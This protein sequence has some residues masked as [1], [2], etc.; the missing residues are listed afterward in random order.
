MFVAVSPLM[1]SC[2]VMWALVNGRRVVVLWIYCYN[3]F[4][5]FFLLYFS[6]LVNSFYLN[7][8]SVL[9]PLL[10]TPVEGEV[11]KQLCGAE[12]PSVLNHNNVYAYTDNLIILCEGL[13]HCSCTN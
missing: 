13:G 6:F 11:S 10:P 9:F 4:L 7:P 12:L 3:R 8:C 1:D 5:I 2:I